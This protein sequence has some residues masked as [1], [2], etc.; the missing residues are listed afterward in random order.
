[1]GLNFGCCVKLEAAAGETQGVHAWL[2]IGCCLILNT[3]TAS[4]GSLFPEYMRT[5]TPVSLINLNQAR[6]NQTRLTQVYMLHISIFMHEI[7]S[8]KTGERNPIREHYTND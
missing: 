6:K 4:A 2:T 1:M 5:P 8:G 3:R 7:I